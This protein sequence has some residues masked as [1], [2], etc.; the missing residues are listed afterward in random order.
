MEATQEGFFE[1][2]LAT[3]K[4]KVSARW[5]E[6]LGYTDRSVA[7]TYESFQA[8]LHPEDLPV[9]QAGMAD[10]ISG[11]STHVFAPI[12][13]R[14]ADGHY[15]PV[16]SRAVVGR[17]A[18]G[19]PSRLVGTILDLTVRARIAKELEV[20]ERRYHDIVEQSPQGIYQTT[21]AGQGLTCNLSCARVLGYE[22]PT[23][24]QQSGLTA[25]SLYV[26]ADCRSQFL[27]ELAAKGM[28]MAFEARMRRKDGRII[29]VSNTARVVRNDAGDVEHIEGFLEDITTRKESEQMK[30]DF[31][32]FATHQLH[33]PLSAIKWLLELV[34]L[35]DVTSE[36]A[37]FIRDARVSADRLINLVND[38]LAVT[39]LES[40]KV[41]V[42]P[43]PVCLSTVTRGVFNELKPLIREKDLT[44]SLSDQAALPE[45]FMDSVLAAEVV[46]NFLS[47]AVRYT[48]AHGTV[49]VGIRVID[50]MVEWSVRDN[51]IGIPIG[52][53]ARLGEKFFRADNASVQHTEGTGLGLYIARLMV[54]RSGGKMSFESTQGFG[55]TFRFTVPIAA[56]VSLTQQTAVAA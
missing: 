15:V 17:T 43:V 48:G 34:E 37:T 41:T 35:T 47:N 32:S 36:S 55:S 5:H 42:K 39:R 16:L 2:D 13:L 46:M 30:A 22:S 27:A 53:Q 8:L 4:S 25:E 23:E 7:S 12:R 20:V 19:K 11:R 9:I 6:I 1:L 3:N 49:A 26:D 50:G 51:G 14:H 21:P 40:G 52:A 33:T 24:I 44:I 10:A 54:E 38:L 31:I 29:W 18:D 45:V 28:V 56:S